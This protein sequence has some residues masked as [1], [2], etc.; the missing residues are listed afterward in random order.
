MIKNGMVDENE[1][2]DS[3]L[4]KETGQ[5]KKAEDSE[6]KVERNYSSQTILDQLQKIVRDA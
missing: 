3:L 1:L 2:R 5:R 6:E 4:E